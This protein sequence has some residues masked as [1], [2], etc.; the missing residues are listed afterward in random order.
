M[1]AFSG[2]RIQNLRCGAMCQKVNVTQCQLNVYNVFV[3]LSFQAE[4][5]DN[6]FCASMRQLVDG[7]CLTLFEQLGNFILVIYVRLTPINQINGTLIERLSAKMIANLLETVQELGCVSELTT[8]VVLRTRYR[9]NVTRGMFV[10]DEIES[11]MHDVVLYVKQNVN[12]DV[13]FKKYMAL[14]NGSTIRIIDKEY[15]WYDFTV[16]IEDKLNFR[17]LK[18]YQ[19]NNFVE[20]FE[21]V[22]EKSENDLVAS[23]TNEKDQTIVK[24]NPVNR[25]CLF[26]K[27]IQI[28]N[29]MHLVDCPLV[30]LFKNDTQW[31][32]LENGNIQTSSMFVFKT[33]T[34]YFKS[35]DSIAVCHK[36]FSSYLSFS[37]VPSKFNAET[38]ISIVCIGCSMLCIALSLIVYALFPTL[39]QTLPG[40][41]TIAL[42]CWL[43]LAQI[44]YLVGGVGGLRP[45]GWPCRVFG[46][47][48]HFSWLCAVFWMNVCTFHMFTVFV[49]TMKM[50]SSAKLKRFIFY[51]MYSLVLP[52]VLVSV[53]IGT[54]VLR[55]GT[56]GYGLYACYIDTQELVIFTFAL[57]MGAVVLVNIVF[58]AIVIFKITRSPSVQKN[59]KNERNDLAI[60]VKLSTI[61]GL[62][63]IFGLI[64]LVTS[65]AVF[66]YL[67][68]ILNA[69]Q[70]V[71]LF[72]AFIAN[73]RVVG[74]VRGRLWGPSG[75]APISR[76]T[77][78]SREVFTNIQF[79]SV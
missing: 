47:L 64:Y 1:L 63:W 46:L 9:G 57:P 21:I 11:I 24:F 13:V 62:T 60:F 3:C 17:D 29:L 19:N 76:S 79:S 6:V 61:T 58:F 50:I 35:Q 23:Y 8:D 25:F 52:L 15:L 56:F 68:I 69:S 30:D 37:V 4:S 42:M 10:R 55:D 33:G 43:L 5:M 7:E 53:N 54:S 49:R 72:A 51:N 41:N 2:T 67:F 28:L 38:I 65:V 36:T 71:F 77:I 32:V 45:N 48:T 44:V 18:T 20:Y 59:T 12:I 31:T 73:R 75:E 26:E 16:S 74:M 14:L 27:P 34:Y 40:K 66:S 70:G 22:T 78:A 39:R